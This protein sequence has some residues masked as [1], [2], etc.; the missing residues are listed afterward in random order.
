MEVILF[1]KSVASSMTIKTD[2][3]LT[4]LRHKRLSYHSGEYIL[5]KSKLTAILTLFAVPVPAK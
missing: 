3:R 1:I 2:I 4:L 5:A